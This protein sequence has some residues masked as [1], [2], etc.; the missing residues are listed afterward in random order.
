MHTA[1]LPFL[2]LLLII[3]YLTGCEG[4]RTFPPVQNVTDFPQTDFVASFEQPFDASQNQL[5]LHHTGICL[6]RNC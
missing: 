5:F 3:F 2:F 6:G 4:S 1:K